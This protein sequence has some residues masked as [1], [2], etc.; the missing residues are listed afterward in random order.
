MAGIVQRLLVDGPHALLRGE[1]TVRE[2][3]PEPLAQG[4]FATPRTYPAVIRI[5]T[6]LKTSPSATLAMRGS[7]HVLSDAS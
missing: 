4:I 5:S 6:N 3:L 1:V 7:K 2:G